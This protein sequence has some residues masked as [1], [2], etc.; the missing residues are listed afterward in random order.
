MTDRTIPDVTDDDRRLAREW[1]ERIIDTPHMSHPVETAAARVI[2]YA[3]LAP[4]HPTLADMTARERVACQ[5]MQAEVAGRDTRY[6][7]TRPYDEDDDVVLIS[8]AGGVVY[9]DPAR[10]TPRPDLPR[11]EWPSDQPEADQ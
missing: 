7:I 4:P 8:D 3:V 6:V 10:V 1:A 2:L 11:L 9:A 5:W